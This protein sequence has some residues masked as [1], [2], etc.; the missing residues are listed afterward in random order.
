MSTKV[1]HQAA[2]I[3]MTTSVVVLGK[4]ILRNITLV[5]WLL[6]MYFSHDIIAAT[7]A[8][9]VKMDIPSTTRSSDSRPAVPPRQELI[10]DRG[11][12]TNFPNAAAHTVTPNAD[13]APPSVLFQARA[14]PTV[15]DRA[16]S[17]LS[18]VANAWVGKYEEAPCAVTVGTCVGLWIARDHP[19]FGCC[20]VCAST[21]MLLTSPERVDAYLRQEAV[22]PTDN[23]R[24]LRTT[25][26]T[27]RRPVRAARSASMSE[28]R[29]SAAP[30]G[31]GAAPRPRAPRAGVNVVAR[32]APGRTDRYRLEPD[33]E[34][35]P[36]AA[37]ETIPPPQHEMMF[38]GSIA[39]SREIRR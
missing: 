1:V 26:T 16:A 39:G 15:K 5:C 35:E 33:A 28:D 2:G 29:S 38:S 22:A 24:R 20:C 34:P 14:V 11:R 27:R 37:F 13:S 6:T 7:Y 23:Q 32:Q 25:S 19:V 3:N 4:L 30:V 10:P 8:V 36:C 12:R 9:K 21:G 31:H 17:C 18:E